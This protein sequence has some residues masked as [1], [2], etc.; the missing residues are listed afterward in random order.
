M[1]CDGLSICW[2]VRKRRRSVSSLELVL[3]PLY[4]CPAGG[5]YR[6]KVCSASAFDDAVAQ[7]TASS[8]P[9]MSIILSLWESG[10]PH[11][12]S[13]ESYFLLMIQKKY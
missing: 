5:G 3:F 10:R 4:R 7:G 11:D 6:R 1:V 9:I 8:L 12:V 13:K 2:I